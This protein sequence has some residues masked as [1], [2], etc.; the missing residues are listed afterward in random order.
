M[1]VHEEFV[2]S[3]I[4]REDQ[5]SHFVDVVTDNLDSYKEDGHDL[6]KLLIEVEKIKPLSAERAAVKA[7]LA[8]LI[9]EGL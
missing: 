6:G 3:A 9:I 5:I 2:N 1:Q 7:I 4:K 8:Y